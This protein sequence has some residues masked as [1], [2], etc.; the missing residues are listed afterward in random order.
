MRFSARA[1]ATAARWDS[2]AWECVKGMSRRRRSSI[3]AS[4]TCSG[5]RDAPAAGLLQLR[6]PVRGVAVQSP[7]AG[8]FGALGLPGQLCLRHYAGGLGAPL[9]L[10]QPGLPVAKSAGAA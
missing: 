9:L 10:P 3:C 4:W 6:A 1:L 8:E 5:S 7:A 2:S